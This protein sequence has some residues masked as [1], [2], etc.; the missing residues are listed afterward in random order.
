MPDKDPNTYGHLISAAMALGASVWGGL[1]AHIL[2]IRRHKKEFLWREAVMQIVVAGFSGV[3]AYM[4]CLYV[5]APDTM[6]GFMSGTAG[7]MGS[8]ALE[9]YERKFTKFIG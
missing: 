2:Y 5:D 9:L 6:I 7:L 8:R 3:L 1:V 4:L